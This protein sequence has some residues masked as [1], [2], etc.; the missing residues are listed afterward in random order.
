MCKL[1]LKELNDYKLTTL[2][3][4]YKKVISVLLDSYYKNTLLEIIKNCDLEVLMQSIVNS[5]KSSKQLACY[6]KSS[7]N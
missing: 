3:S 7:F 6:F 5:D 2:S 4:D 1:Y